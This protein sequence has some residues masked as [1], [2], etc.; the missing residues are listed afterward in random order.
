MSNS[1]NYYKGKNILIIGGS[2]GIGEALCRSL[3]QAGG[4]L[5]IIARSQDKLDK[6][7]DEL[8]GDNIG[9]ACDISKKSDLNKLYKSISNKWQ[10]IDLVLFCV[11]TYQPMNLENFNLKQA[12]QII[13]INLTSFLGFLD[14]FLPLFKAQRIAHLAVISSVAGY[15]GMPNSLAYG[16]SKAALSNLTES[17][18]HEL[19]KYKTKVQ[20]INPGFVKTR[21]TDQNNFKMPGIITSEQAAQSILT[22]LPKSKFEIAFPFNFTLIMKAIAS[23]PY[24]IRFYLFKNVK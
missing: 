21:L 6:L 17:L 7:C 19:R 22:Q 3:S 13:D 14:S 10:K 16:A 12:Q 20:L 24:K 18:H 8:A 2:F 4:N 1:S 5:A 23:L 9:I 15:F 11:G